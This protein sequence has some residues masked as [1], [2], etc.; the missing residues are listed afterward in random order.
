MEIEN[1]ISC[2]DKI[3]HGVVDFGLFKFYNL[4]IEM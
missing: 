3:L 4:K 1:I 2:V